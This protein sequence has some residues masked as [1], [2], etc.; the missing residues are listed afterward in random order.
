MWE[1]ERILNE[2]KELNSM[3]D[4]L[5][6]E[7]VTAIHSEKNRP[8]LQ[9]WTEFLESIGYSNYMQDLNAA[10]YG[11][12]QHRERTFVVSLLGQYNYKFPL[13]IELYTCL[14]DY[15]EELTEEQAL[16]QIVKS[17]KA[18]SLLVELDEKG[19]LEETDS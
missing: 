19:E 11:I 13:P 2:L 1:V 17:E 7:N 6:M 16:K 8:H 15:F 5:L 9:K 10:D 18:M 12:A 4:V 3:P 14:E